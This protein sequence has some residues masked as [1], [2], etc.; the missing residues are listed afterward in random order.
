MGVALAL[1]RVICHGLGTWGRGRFPFQASIP[2]AACGLL[3]PVAALSQCSELLCPSLLWFRDQVWLCQVRSCL[4]TKKPFPP[5]FIFRCLQKHNRRSSNSLICHL[6]LIVTHLKSL[7]QLL[8]FCQ[9]NHFNI[10]QMAPLPAGALH[11]Q[12]PV[13]FGGRITNSCPKAAK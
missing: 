2:R 9:C 13:G 1:C 5:N 12:T 3:Q 8:F 6:P 4:V 7:F 10:V 11:D